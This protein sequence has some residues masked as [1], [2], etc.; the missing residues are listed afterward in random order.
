MFYRIDWSVKLFLLLK[1]TVS[2]FSGLCVCLFDDPIPLRAMC[3]GWRVTPG[4]YAP[5]THTVLIT[6]NIGNWHISV[7]RGLGSRFRR[8]SRFSPLIACASIDRPPPDARFAGVIDKTLSSRCHIPR[9]TGRRNARIKC[10]G[11]HKG[12][13]IFTTH[14]RLHRGYA[15]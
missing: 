6:G 1:L 3:P 5:G 15:R 13:D 11:R 4:G 12:D 9:R 8:F 10:R 2:S 7:Q 14:P